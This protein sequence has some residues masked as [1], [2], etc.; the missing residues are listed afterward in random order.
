MH[1]I[2]MD[3]E[4]AVQDLHLVGAALGG[5]DKSL[6]GAGVQSAW[7]AIQRQGAGKQG[8]FFQIIHIELIA[9]AIAGGNDQAARVVTVIMVV[10]MVMGVFTA[11][12]R[13]AA[14]FVFTAG[15]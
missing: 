12:Q 5:Q 8:L 11:A 6:A 1:M 9:G 3:I 10:I 14:G 4:A 7:G 15:Q 13:G 2:V